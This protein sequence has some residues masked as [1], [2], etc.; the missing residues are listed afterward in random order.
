MA[1]L[2]IA[3]APP[4]TIAPC[5]PNCHDVALKEKIHNISAWP[6]SAPTM[7]NSTCDKPRPNTSERMLRSLGRLNSSPMTNIRNTTP[8]SARYLMLAVS[9]ASASAFGP[10]STPTT[11]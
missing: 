3:I 8:N 11:R 5:Q 10:I 9:L 2:D 4:S 7:V 1:V 6:S